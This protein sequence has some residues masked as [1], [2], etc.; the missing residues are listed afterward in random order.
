MDWYNCD[1]KPICQSGR[2]ST[3][4]QNVYRIII[5]IQIML[6][7]D[8]YAFYLGKSYIFILHL[9][10]IQVANLLIVTRSDHYLFVW[11]NDTLNCHSN[12]NFQI[13]THC[14]LLPHWIS[15]SVNLV[16]LPM[17]GDIFRQCK[18]KHNTA[19]MGYSLPM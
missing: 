17:Q 10:V 1:D 14:S 2:N 18:G 3:I 7:Y 5:T 6:I 8:I 15:I 12:P 11:D 13:T 19:V 4:K 9:Y 16:I